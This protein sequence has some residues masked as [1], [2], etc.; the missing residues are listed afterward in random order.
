MVILAWRM[1]RQRPMSAVATFVALWFG[2]AVITACG[3]LLESGIRYHGTPERYAASSVLVAT[4]DLRVISGQGDNRDVQR[5]PLPDRG[6]IDAGLTTQ[7]AGLPGVRTAVADVATPTQVL[8]AQG[9]D[10]EDAQVH[11]WSAAVLA[12][13]TLRAGVAPA[14]DGQIVLDATTAQRLGAHPGSSVRLILGSGVHTFTVSGIAAPS[15]H[16][17]ADPTVFLTDAQARAV[18][19]HPSTVDVI[20]LIGQPGVPAATLAKAADGI[21]PDA[22]RDA[23]GTFP[24]VFSGADRGLVETPDVAEA[25]ELAT[26]LPSVFG[27]CTIL[28]AALVIAGTVGLSVQQ[29]HRDIALL[30]AIGATPRQMRRMVVRESAV[31]AVLAAATGV[32]GGFAGVWWLRDQF[33]HRGITPASF[34]VHISWIPP[35]VAAAVGLIISIGA[36]WVA[37]LRASRIHPTEALVESSVER[38]RGGW[39]RIPLGLAGLGGGVVL[40]ITASR[41]RGDD[42]ASVALSVVATLVTAVWL[43]APWLNRLTAAI[44]GVG[45][46]A[47]GVTGRLAAANSAASARR[48]APVLTSLVLA[49]GFG[50]SMMF[51]QT[52]IKHTAAQQSHAGLRADYVVVPSGSGLPSGVAAA[53]RQ[54]PG[55]TAADGVVHSSVLDRKDGGTQYSA[56]TPSDLVDLGVTSGRLADLHGNTIAIDNLTADSENVHVGSSMHVWFADGT[57]T[58]LRVVAT[59]TRGLGFAAT[60]LPADVL[61]PHTAGLDSSVLL[62]ATPAARAGVERL[63]GQV[64]PGAEV[65]SR[66]D[67]QVA[68]DKDVAQGAWANQMV[69]SVLLVYV[70]IAAVNTLAMAAMGRRRELATLRL[71]GTTRKQ[72]LRMVRIEQ[73]LLLGVGLI[74]GGAIAAATLMPL[75]KATTGTST[76]YIPPI[77]WASVI[78]G[79]VLLAL[80]A[81][82]LPVRRLLRQDPVGA[83]GIRE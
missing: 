72:I 6:R 35:V 32:W 51:M 9:T 83:I 21:V 23:E 34:T 10:A 44:A 55:V 76:P 50:G 46:R 40:A 56:Q 30:R 2:V 74:I 68:L 81:T 61:A 1:L 37:S 71:S 20:G 63:L 26:A 70:A 49:I 59:Y 25:R 5:L 78:G 39:L 54:V 73:G 38:R 14:A 65:L 79:T 36:A 67:Y 33:V 3:V 31:L 16:P 27:G 80:G 19:G 43:L 77:G 52:S 11:P 41:L 17:P 18:S 13:F 66:A 28:I 8:P 42:A 64:A 53:L 60:T 62:R 69:V 82:V 7:L 29:R 4:T 24:R 12:P 75:V 58:E 57:P 15:G 48:L 22:P 47:M 45:M